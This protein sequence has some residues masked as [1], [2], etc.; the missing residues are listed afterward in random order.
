MA[1][2]H[3]AD[4]LNGLQVSGNPPATPTAVRAVNSVVRQAM[5]QPIPTGRR[6]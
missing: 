2:N 1:L 6:R 3:I 5:E 4:K